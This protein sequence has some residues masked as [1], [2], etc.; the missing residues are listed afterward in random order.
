MKKT[1]DKTTF[2]KVAN[3]EKKKNKAK[4]SRNKKPPIDNEKTIIVKKPIKAKSFK[5]DEQPIIEQ[6]IVEQPIIEQPIIEQ[7]IIEQPII[8]PIKPTEKRG[9]HKKDC[10]CDK[11]IERKSKKELKPEG[12]KYDLSKP[13]HME[14]MLNELNDIEKNTPKTEQ[15]TTATNIEGEQVAE[16]V[17]LLIDGYMLLIIT[18]TIFPLG[19]SFFM[20]K[21]LKKDVS[22]KDIKLTAEEFTKLEPIAD[23]TAEYL[24]LNMNPL[25]VFALSVGSIYFAKV[26]ENV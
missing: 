5:K 15:T 4:P 19:I 2:K 13:D 20:K 10:T 21:F 7:P 22:V 8:E 23:K 1:A 17:T 3:A 18:D 9:R 25:L 12:E 24:S 16:K 26:I 11:C 14:K 6:P